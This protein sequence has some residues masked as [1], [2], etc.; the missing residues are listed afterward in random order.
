MIRLANRD[1]GENEV[2]PLPSGGNYCS[3]AI[4]QLTDNLEKF[5][6]EMRS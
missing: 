2:F 5:A 1:F 3:L 4:G 6:E